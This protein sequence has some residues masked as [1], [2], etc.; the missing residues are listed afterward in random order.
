M[1]FLCQKRVAELVH[2]EAVVILGEFPGSNQ[3][4]IFVLISNYFQTIIPLSQ[5]RISEFYSLI[6]FLKSAKISWGEKSDAPFSNG[7]FDDGSAPLGD[8]FRFDVFDRVGDDRREIDA[9]Q[10]AHVCEGSCRVSG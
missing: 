9:D 2:K 4:Q 1:E 3:S 5:L 10:L 8:V 7:H 6:F